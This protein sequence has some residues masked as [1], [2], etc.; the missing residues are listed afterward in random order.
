[1]L[2][3]YLFEKETK[4]IYSKLSQIKMILKNYIISKF[5]WNYYRDDEDETIDYPK[6]TLNETKIE[7]GRINLAICCVHTIHFVLFLLLCAYNK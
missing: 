7:E 1:M 3:L 6:K 4:Y 2:S 5:I